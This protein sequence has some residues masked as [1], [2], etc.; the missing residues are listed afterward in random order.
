MQAARQP[1]SDS[2]ADWASR[3]AHRCCIHHV[4]SPGALQ[5]VVGPLKVLALILEL[6]VGHGCCW[7]CVLPWDQRS[8]AGAD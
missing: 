3:R 1:G 8:R 6:R 2:N 4:L 5:L 7:S